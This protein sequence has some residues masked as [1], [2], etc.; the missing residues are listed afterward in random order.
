MSV[1]AFGTWKH[2]KVL[3]FT[4][5]VFLICSPFRIIWFWYAYIRI[6]ITR[7]T[8]E[9]FVEKDKATGNVAN[10]ITLEDLNSVIYKSTEIGLRN[11]LL[12][13]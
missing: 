10:T 13:S 9:K 4:H 8:K 6:L 3:F 12:E 7:K 11:C 1:V 5:T 2:F